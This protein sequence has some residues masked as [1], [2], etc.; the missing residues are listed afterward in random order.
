MPTKDVF[1]G[2]IAWEHEQ[3]KK[4]EQFERDVQRGVEAL[5]AKRQN[6]IGKK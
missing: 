5:T 6:R 4:R 2:Y 1:T 3:A